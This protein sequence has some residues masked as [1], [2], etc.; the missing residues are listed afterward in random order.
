[1]VTFVEIV[2]ALSKKSTEEQLVLLPGRVSVSIL[3]VQNMFSVKPAVSLFDAVGVVV[4]VVEDSAVAELTVVVVVVVVV[5]A[6]VSGKFKSCFQLL[7]SDV[8]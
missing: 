6:V 2:Y 5:V 3:A 1:M 8:D 7:F 4:V